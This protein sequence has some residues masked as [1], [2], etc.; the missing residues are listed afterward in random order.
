[1]YMPKFSTPRLPLDG[2]PI[3]DDRFFDNFG[4]LNNTWYLY[5]NEPLKE[6]LETFAQFPIAT[7][8]NRN[9]PKL[10]LVS[11]DV[12]EGAVV[13]FDSYPKDEQGTRRE[14]GYGEFMLPENDDP[15]NG[16]YKYTTS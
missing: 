10:L 6:S 8:F 4:P 5:S 16:H 13:T 9:E 12:Q 1:V 14:S 15:K 11:V 3:L 7:S 2:F